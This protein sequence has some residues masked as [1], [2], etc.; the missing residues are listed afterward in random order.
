VVLQHAGDS[1]TDSE[2]A[3]AGVLATSSA[4]SATM[5]KN[6]RPMSQIPM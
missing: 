6:F 4:K 5:A 1:E 2:S 3:S